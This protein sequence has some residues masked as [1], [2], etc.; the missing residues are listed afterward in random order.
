MEQER[1]RIEEQKKAELHDKLTKEQ[2]KKQKQEEERLKQ[3]EEKRIKEQQ[4]EQEKFEKEAEKKRIAEE[5][6]AA[7]ESAK[8]A[9]EEERLRKEELKRIEREEKEFQK[10]RAKEAEKIK[11]DK[12]REF[13]P[14]PA[15]ALPADKNAKL[16]IAGRVLKGRYGVARIQIKLLADGKTDTFLTDK[17]GYYLIP[18]LERDKDY[19]VTVVSDNNVLNISPKSRVYKKIN[20]D[21]TN[22][23]YYVV[24]EK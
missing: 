14:T 17:Y 18:D 13:Q 20:V 3:E 11:E 23:N 10:I 1:L 21:F 8:K 7:K 16:S 9:K 5:K 12:K 15:D 2:E 4:K 24:T 19:V 6:L 22:H